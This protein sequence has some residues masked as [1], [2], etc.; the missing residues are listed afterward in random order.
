M[1]EKIN[2]STVWNQ[3]LCRTAPANK[4]CCGDLKL[5]KTFVLF[6]CSFTYSRVWKQLNNRWNRSTHR[7]RR[8]SHRR[9]LVCSLSKNRIAFVL[10]SAQPRPIGVCAERSATYRPKLWL[11]IKRRVS[12][13]YIARILQEKHCLFDTVS[14]RFGC[15]EHK[16]A[17]EDCWK[18]VISF[19]CDRHMQFLVHNLQ[20]HEK[21]QFW[22]YCSHLVAFGKLCKVN[23]IWKFRV[24]P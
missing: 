12:L 9:R 16:K 14:E 7:R 13:F 6:F 10:R 19:A 3:F 1:S 4:Y 24:M 20:K 2:I 22:R 17:L 8:G 18:T 23:T 5:S 11:D 21:L 15:F